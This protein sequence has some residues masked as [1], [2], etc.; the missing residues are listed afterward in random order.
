M[1]A[2]LWPSNT[3]GFGSAINVGSIEDIKQAI[4]DGNGFAYY[5]E[6]RMWI[7]EY[8]SDALAKAQAVVLPSG[9]LGHGGRRRR[10]LPEV[11]PPRLP[12]P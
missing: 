10:P 4:T 6:G 1:L 11:P 3:G 2:F 5:P 8:P 12:R 7:T 9:A